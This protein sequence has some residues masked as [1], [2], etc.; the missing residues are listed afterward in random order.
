[1]PEALQLIVGV[2]A[3]LVSFFAVLWTKGFTA[4]DRELFTMRKDEVRELREAEEAAV[5]RGQVGDDV[6]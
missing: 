3:I 6:V 2:P 1:L 5:S 4:E